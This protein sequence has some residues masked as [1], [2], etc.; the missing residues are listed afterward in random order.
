MIFIIIENQ[1]IQVRW[2]NSNYNWYISKGYNFTKRNEKF[3]V[4]AEDL[5]P[6]S[7]QKVKVQCDYCGKI[8]EQNYHSY[9]LGTKKFPFKACCHNCT[10]K[11]ARET[12]LKRRQD[13]LFNEVQQRCDELGYILLTKKEDILTCKQKIEYICPIHGKVSQV[14][15][16]LLRG[17]VCN[18]C[19]NIAI[20]KKNLKNKQNIH[21]LINKDGNVWLNPD[22]YTGTFDLN[23]KIKCKCG[24]EFTTSL[25]NYRHGITKCKSCTHS[26]SKGE[27]TIKDFLDQ[28]HISY[29]REKKF[30]DCKDK[31]PLPFDFYLPKENMCI[32]F[33][34]IQHYKPIYSDWRLEYVHKHDNMKTKYCKE[35][36]IDL[37]RIPYWDYKN[38]NNI[39]EE[40]VK[41]KK[42]I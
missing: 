17:H 16:H 35:N 38:I 27:E 26:L 31:R 11:K 13:K 14:I 15:D 3:V 10:G 4:K 6:G 40:N 8:Y 39:L 36:H 1:L 25:A 33:D 18:K 34:G 23:L 32:E 41:N 20:G 2:N 12:S 22:E 29:E 5:P 30:K 21:K 7:A 24:K 42:V 37:L 28:N 19:G 9:V